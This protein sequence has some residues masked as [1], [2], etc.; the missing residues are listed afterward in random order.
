MMSQ[1]G[2]AR[3]SSMISRARAWAYVCKAEGADFTSTVGSKLPTR[4]VRYS[5]LSEGKQTRAKSRRGEPARPAGSRHPELAG[6]RGHRMPQSRAVKQAD[7]QWRLFMRAGPLVL[8]GTL[9]S[10]SIFGALDQPLLSCRAGSG[11]W[12]QTEGWRRG[13]QASRERGSDKRLIGSRRESLPLG[14]GFR[15]PSQQ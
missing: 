1:R 14:S 11:M 10:A 2:T 12:D 5:S 15:R 13:Q 9:L 6:I 8:A 3:N 4:N 7:S